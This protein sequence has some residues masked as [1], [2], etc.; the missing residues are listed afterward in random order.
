MK[1]LFCEDLLYKY[2]DSNYRDFFCPTIYY[3]FLN[4]LQ[5]TDTQSLISLCFRHSCNLVCKS[6]AKDFLEEVFGKNLMT[7][8]I[9]VQPFMS[10]VFHHC[11]VW[12]S[13]TEP[14]TLALNI[15]LCQSY[16]CTN[17]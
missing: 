15:L 1:R 2:V 12:G 4:G 5:W 16:C 6:A 7:P 14:V 8:V 13:L 9:V 3:V 17:A 11:L 10:R